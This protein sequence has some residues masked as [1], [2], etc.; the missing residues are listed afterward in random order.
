MDLSGIKHNF[1]TNL[2][3]LR[4]SRNINQIELGEA[5]HYSSKAISKWE[6]EETIP[7]IEVIKT[8]ADYFGVTVDEIISDKD[9]VRKSY[10]KRNHFLISLVSSLLPLFLALVAFSF[11][12]IYSIDKSYISFFLGMSASA[13]TLIVF[14]SIWYTKTHIF[15]S[16]VYLLV[17]LMLLALFIIGF[18]YWWIYTI[19]SFS[20]SVLF[21]FF[22]MINFQN[23][24]KKKQKK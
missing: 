14:S 7:S 22:F 4:K 20:L 9:V 15:F 16:I 3:K 18:E 2:I 1:A 10:K 6:N 5:I 24:G 13:I 23:H 8:I 19:I 11:L 12:Y 21:F 17:S